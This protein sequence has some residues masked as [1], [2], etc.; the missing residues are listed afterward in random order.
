MGEHNQLQYVT[1]SYIIYTDNPYN[2]KQSGKDVITDFKGKVY[3]EVLTDVPTRYYHIFGM[4][5]IKAIQGSGLF[6]LKLDLTGKNLLQIS[7]AKVLDYLKVSYFG[8]SVNSHQTCTNC[9]STNYLTYSSD[10][11]LCEYQC[12]TE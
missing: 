11:D 10:E 5:G 6:S 12:R 2:I 9:R 8:I 7:S 1:V 3:R 4:S